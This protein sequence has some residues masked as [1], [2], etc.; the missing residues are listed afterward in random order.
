MRPRNFCGYGLVLVGS[1][2]LL[3]GACADGPDQA[4]DDSLGRVQRSGVLRVAVDPTYPPM[5]FEE[6]GQPVGF[7]IDLARALA[8][9]LGVRAEF[10]VAD[11]AGIVAGLNAGRYD[12]ILS[13]MNITAERRAQVA[14]VEY[15]TVP[16]VFVCRR[17]VFVGSAQDL[18]DKAVVVQVNTTSHAWVEALS[19]QGMAPRQLKALPTPTD[20]FTAVRVGQADVVVVDEPVGRYYAR[21]DPTLAVTGEALAAE[22]IGIALRRQDQALQ[23]AL[24]AAVAELRQ[25]GT[26]RQLAE[27]WFGAALDR[28]D[29]VVPADFWGF[30]RGVVLPRLLLGL[31]LTLEL[32]VVSGLCGI[33]LGLVLALAPVSRS[34]LLRQAVLVYVTLFRGTPLLLQVFFIYY[35]LPSLLDL[36]LGALTAGILALALNMAA[37]VSEIMRAAIESIDKGQMEAARSLGMS[38]AQAL[39]WVILP[40][41]A[42]RMLPPLVNELAALAKDTSLVSVLALHEML[43]ETNR[44]AAA[45]L[46]PWEVYLWAGLGYLTLVLALTALAGRLDRRLR[47][48]ES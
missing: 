19:R 13:S 29:T 28:A 40:Q 38:H 31:R 26:L 1:A 45:Y 27:H 41:A 11:W 22:P 8:R 42:R 21:A 17:G 35:G 47:I 25:D 14:F 23:A 4:R 46:R 9:Q 15:A 16:Q 24:A 20:A 36:R 7:D 32:T 12:V 6:Q 39:A 37:Y 2:V 5:E 34:R 18:A 33:G 48:A 3:A 43:Y 30:S 10:V 44:L